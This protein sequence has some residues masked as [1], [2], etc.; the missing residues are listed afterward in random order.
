MNS[1]A[2]K[3]VVVTGGEGLLGKSIISK[4]KELSATPISA[5][6]ANDKS[7]EGKVKIDITSGSSIENAIDNVCHKY[8]R[9]DGWVNNAY[10]R[11]N[12]WGLEFEKIPFESWRANVDMHLN[13][14][15]LCSQ[16]VLKKMRQQSSGTLINMASIYGIVGPDF[17]VYQGTAMTMPAAY[18][19]IKGGLITLSKYLASYY[20]PHGITVN[21]ISPGGIFDNQPTSFVKNYEEK[22]PSR[23]LGK[24]EDVSGAVAF[25]ISDEARYINGHN[26]VIDGGWSAI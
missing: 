11:T 18:A 24:P 7:E 15:F 22:V 5:D 2:G 8:G 19:A 12:D 21:C 3:I 13:G 20:G 9:I 23:R 16:I 26:L 25:L 4:L 6:I 14:Y 10:P 1:L 17:S